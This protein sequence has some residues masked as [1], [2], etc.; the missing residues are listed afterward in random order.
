MAV[1]VTWLLE[2]GVWVGYLGWLLNYRLNIRVWER[3]ATRHE[4]NSIFH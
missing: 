2:L 3:D 4:F 1:K